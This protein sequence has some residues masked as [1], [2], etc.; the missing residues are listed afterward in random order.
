[1]SSLSSHN[2]LLVSFGD[3]EFLIELHNPDA[4]LI[5]DNSHETLSNV[6]DLI[7]PVQKLDMPGHGALGVGITRQ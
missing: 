4:S 5:G 1:M 7:V 2:K 3:A 6:A